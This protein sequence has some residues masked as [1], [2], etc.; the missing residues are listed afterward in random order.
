MT[1]IKSQDM[2]QENKRSHTATHTAT[3]TIFIALL[4]SIVCIVHNIIQGILFLLAKRKTILKSYL[5]WLRIS[6][7]FP[8][9]QFSI[10]A[11][12]D[13]S[14]KSTMLLLLWENIVWENEM[15][16]RIFNIQLCNF[17]F[18][19]IDKTVLISDF[20]SPYLP[21]LKQITEKLQQL[22]FTYYIH[23]NI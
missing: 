3:F 8:L 19:W 1:M 20:L 14:S 13:A 11:L 5:I 15:R 9:Y 16:H 4:S 10:S 6:N 17:E 21:K 22:S 12:H 7:V 2:R 23:I 18:L